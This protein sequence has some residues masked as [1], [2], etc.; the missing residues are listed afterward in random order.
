MS[1]VSVLG[2]SPSPDIFMLSEDEPI[3][4]RHTWWNPSESI[5]PYPRWR[6]KTRCA[7]PPENDA[8]LSGPKTP[9]NRAS[10]A[11]GHRV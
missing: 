4:S 6:A 11:A 7:S 8:L 5:E 3:S 9:R 1:G 10:A 2:F